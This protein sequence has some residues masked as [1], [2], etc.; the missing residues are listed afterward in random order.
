MPLN[1]S[2]IHLGIPRGSDL[3]AHGYVDNKGKIGRVPKCLYYVML[4][5]C[6]SVENI[7]LDDKFD[8]D[9]IRCNAQALKEA[10]I[11]DEKSL[12]E[13][14]KND[15]YDIFYIN[16]RS[17]SK[18]ERDLWHDIGAKNSRYV[19]LSETWIEPSRET[20]IATED[21]FMYHSS[22][23]RGKGCAIVSPEQHSQ[24]FSVCT[25]DFQVMS[26]PLANLQLTVVYL[27]KEAE[28]EDVRRALIQT[29][30]ENVS[31]IILGDFNFTPADSNCIK[32]YLC[33]QGLY[34]MISQPTH[35]EGRILDQLYVSKEFKDKIDFTVQFKYFSDH[36]A[37]QI[38]IKE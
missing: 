35:H 23:G 6:A 27:S 31:Q 3:I 17:F 5:R 16:V 29:L 13:A 20:P 8:I 1:I 34:Q 38:K 25:K 14:K 26:V 19:C 4:S 10:A 2:C 24:V 7:Y 33:H 28:K 18:H 11:L 30:D 15:I 22:F 12:N 21:K 9:Q 37:F 36:A 32:D